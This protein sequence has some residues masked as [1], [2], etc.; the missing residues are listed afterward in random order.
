LG[1]G[2]SSRLFQEVREKR[3]LAY[4]VQ[5][6]LSAYADSGV[7]G[8]YAAT[9]ETKAPEMLPVIC[10]EVMKLQKG[11]GENEITRA[12]N[13][14]KASLFMSR[15]STSS[16]AEWIGRHLLNYKHYKPA[17]EIAALIDHVSVD[18]ITRISASITG[19]TLTLAALGPQKGLPEYGKVQERFAV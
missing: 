11:V 13:Q 19:D 15:E 2:M 1:G 7:L 9:H 12:K 8:I 3:G 4:T 17:A 6:F 16:I 5:A 14:I 18:D 10:D